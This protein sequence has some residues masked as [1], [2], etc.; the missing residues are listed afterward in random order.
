MAGLRGLAGAGPRFR[1]NGGV[2]RGGRHVRLGRQ[3][4][5]VEGRFREPANDYFATN[6]IPLLEG[7][8][9]TSADRLGD[10]LVVIVNQTLAEQLWPGDAAIGKRVQ[11]TGGLRGSADS[12]NPEFFPD[13]WMT[14]VG[15]A[16]DIRRESSSEAPRPEYY[17]PHSQIT[18]GFQ[19]LMVRAVS[20]P[21]EVAPMIRQTVWPLDSSVPVDEVRTMQVQV[22]KS[23]ATPRFRTIMLVSFA[24]FTCLL[25]MV[26]LYAIMSLAVT[27]RRREMGIR[28]ALGARRS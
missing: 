8:D 4:G 15:V 10:P 24:G 1:R 12:F 22:A 11:Y 2:R 18:W 14:V 27:R 7:R 17:R 5:V 16:A 25:A 21:L 9:F 19:Y 23:V 13:S 6:S 20:D 28:L 26:G 3:R